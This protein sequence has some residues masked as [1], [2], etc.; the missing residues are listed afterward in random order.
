MDGQKKID[1]KF[2]FFI[3]NSI[4]HSVIKTSQTYV[5][6]LLF[7]LTFAHIHYICAN[8]SCNITYFFTVLNMFLPCNS[9][10]TLYCIIQDL[11]ICN[12]A[13]L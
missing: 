10:R 13:K 3:L 1:K 4:P 5:L 9:T 8:T 2:F 11:L 12:S 6:H 7:M